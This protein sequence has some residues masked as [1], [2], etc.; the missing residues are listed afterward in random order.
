MGAG[1]DRGDVPIAGEERRDS[2]RR[3]AARPRS[4]FQLPDRRP[5]TPLYSRECGLFAILATLSDS[6]L[7]SVPSITFPPGK[8]ADWARAGRAGTKGHRNRQHDLRRP[9]RRANLRRRAHLG[10]HRER[11]A[12][13]TILTVG[14]LND[15][16]CVYLRV[17]CE[18]SFR[19]SQ[20]DISLSSLFCLLLPHA[21]RDVLCHT[22]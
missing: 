7:T 14:D 13:S 10:A 5:R 6:R 3:G 9:R 15:L 21:A 20:L 19:N 16:L 11:R 12:L 1:S 8:R 2:A 4:P 22:D 17:R 18:L